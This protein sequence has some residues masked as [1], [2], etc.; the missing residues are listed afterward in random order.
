MKV[1]DAILQY[2][3]LHLTTDATDKKLKFSHPVWEQA[4]LKFQCKC[5]SE[6]ASKG[7]Q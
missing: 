1:A 2:R 4:T 3:E 7:M 5:F 6:K